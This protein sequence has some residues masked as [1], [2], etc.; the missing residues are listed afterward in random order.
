MFSVAMESGV[1]CSY[2]KN[3]SDKAAEDP[4]LLRLKSLHTSLC[5]L[6]RVECVSYKSYHLVNVIMISYLL[7]VFSLYERCDIVCA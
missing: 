4:I 1:Q 7:I 3:R 5:C 6:N 2:R